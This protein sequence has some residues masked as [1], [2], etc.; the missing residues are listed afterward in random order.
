LIW[1]VGIN[2]FGLNW[3]RFLVAV[4]GE[5]RVIGSGQIKPHGDGPRELASIA[6]QPE[7]QGQGIGREIIERLLSENP[8]PLYLTCRPRMAPYYER[9]GFRVLSPEEMPSYFRRIYQVVS[10]FSR[11]APGAGEMRVMVKTA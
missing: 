1:R 8:L 4:D 5:D 6:V 3:R 10:F 11:L 2:P 7:W 9:F